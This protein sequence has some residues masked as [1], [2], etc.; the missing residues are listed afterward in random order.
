M[1]ATLTVSISERVLAYLQQRAIAEQTT[2]EAV[3]AQQLDR[4]VPP[5]SE[6]LRKWIG[7]FSSGVTDASIR[8][9]EYIGQA[10]FEE[11]TGERTK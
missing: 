3:A 2:P 6:F 11:L 5:T 9:D 7:A 10:L 4:A 8:H 1:A